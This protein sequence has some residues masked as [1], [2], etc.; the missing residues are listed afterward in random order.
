MNTVQQLQSELQRHAEVRQR[1]TIALQNQIRGFPDNPNIQRCGN[2]DCCFK[3]SSSHIGNNWS[4]EHHDFRLQ[5]DAIAQ[6][7][8]VAADPVKCLKNIIEKGCVTTGQRHTVKLHKAVIDYIRPW[9][10]I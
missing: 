10:E 6:Q 8:Q 3:M 7:L 1:L 2:N 4:V 5:Y 9:V